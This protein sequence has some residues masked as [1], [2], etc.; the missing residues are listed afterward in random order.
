MG[1]VRPPAGARCP[2]CPGPGTADR[3]AAGRSGL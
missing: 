3:A 2:A 1:S